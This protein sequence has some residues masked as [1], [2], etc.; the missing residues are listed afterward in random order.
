[1]FKGVKSKQ[2]CSI[3]R[4][5]KEFEGQRRFVLFMTGTHA[6][7]SVR[8]NWLTHARPWR[9]QISTFIMSSWVIFISWVIFLQHLK[10]G[11]KI[12]IFCPPKEYAFVTHLDVLIFDGRKQELFFS[13]EPWICIM[14]NIR[15]EILKNPECQGQCHRKRIVNRLFINLHPIVKSKV[16]LVR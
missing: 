9:S 12:W 5:F 14:C 1:M 16:N 13:F 11:G 8:T 3:Y 6:L 2:I 7:R 4:N 10:P 15:I